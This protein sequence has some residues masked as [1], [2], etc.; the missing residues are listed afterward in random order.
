MTYT[1]T[2]TFKTRIAAEEALEKLEQAGIGEDQMSLVVTDETR[3]RSFNIDEGSKVDEGVAA[4][5][6]AGGIVGAILGSVLAAGVVAIPGLNIVIAGGLI[7]GLAGFGAGAAAG[8]LVGGLIGMGIPEHE[9]RL[10]EAQ[11]KD[12]AILL[13]VMGKDG[14]QKKTV[15][16]ILHSVDAYHV[17]A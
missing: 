17:A 4:G 1:I 13:A 5:A 16:E 6:T 7:S 9:A 11:V 10:H 8:G 12:G 14:E 15:K 2:A 3:G